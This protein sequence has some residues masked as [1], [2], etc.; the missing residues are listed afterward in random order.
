MGLWN[1][2]PRVALHAHLDGELSLEGTLV[3]EEHLGQCETCRCE[4]ERLG[5]LQRVLRSG[6]ALADRVKVRRT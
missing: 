3:V 6:R 1:E 2:H 5:T 4:L